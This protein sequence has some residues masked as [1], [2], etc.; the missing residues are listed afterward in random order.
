MGIFVGILLLSVMMVV[1][2]LG[3]FLTGLMLGFKI[4]EFSLFMGPTLLKWD[5][6]G[7]RY[8]LKLLPI[9]A[10]VRFGGEAGDDPDAPDADPTLFFNRPRWARAI[11]IGTGPAINLLSGILAF[12]IMFSVFGYTLPELYKVDKNT[13][14]ANA[15]LVA[16][17]R[18]IAANGTAIRTSLD[19]MSVETLT[20]A[21]QPLL[22]SVKGTD[23]SVRQV[24]LEPTK[25]KGYRLGITVDL[26][27]PLAEGVLIS[28]VDAS[29]NGG[30][31][32]LKAGDILLSANGVPYDNTKT[33]F[34]DAVDKSA[35]QPLSVDVIRDGQRQTLAMVATS[36]EGYLSRGIWFTS[37]HAF[38][39]AV[40]QAFKWS[41]SVVTVTVHSLGLIFSGRISAKDSLSGPV[42]VV[43]MISNVVDQK[44]QVSDKI[45]QLLWM[46]ALISVNLGFMNLLPIPPLDGH[47]L[48]LI[49]IEAIRRRRLALRTQNIIGMVGIVLIIS[50]AFA[51]LLFDILRLT[52]N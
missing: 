47:H 14:A 36:Y 32:V 12:A 16:G 35:G 43:S 37:G 21:D 33:D 40:G 15:G 9:G 27:N 34:R 7:I 18:V 20:P 44:A 17:D 39:P 24:N 23:G 26:T 4:E 8:S 48:V 51:G 5:R 50:L 1:H 52:G 49:A 10:S 31:P 22:L 38:L 42:G 25:L 2:E 6:K 41:W 30:N 3:H 28:A 11:V 45:Y 46:F 19:Y 29:S 13:L